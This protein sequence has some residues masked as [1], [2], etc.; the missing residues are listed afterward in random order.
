MTNAIHE[1][2]PYLCVRDV[3]AAI[4][5][6]ARALGAREHYR[7]TEPSGRVGHAEVHFGDHIVMLAD[8]YPELGFTAPS[9]GQP[10]RFSLHLHVDDADATF[11]TALAAGAVAE[12]DPT[13]Q[14]YGERSGSIIDPFGYRWMLGHSIEDVSVDAM[15]ARYRRLL[16]GG[17]QMR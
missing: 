1:V 15:Q 14:F 5:F 16:C 3:D 12:R 8:E 17:D 9:I 7:L 2:F 10:H 11:A 4:D 13:D 6:Y